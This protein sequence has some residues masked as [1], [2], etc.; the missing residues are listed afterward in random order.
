MIVSR[1]RRIIYSLLTLVLVAHFATTTTAQSSLIPNGVFE[2][3]TVSE[4]PYV[5]PIEW[6]SLNE[7]HFLLGYDQYTVQKTNDAYEGSFAL[8]IETQKLCTGVS[9]QEICL[10]VPGAAVLGELFIHPADLSIITFGVD[11]FERPE[12]MTGWYKYQPVSGDSCLIV[13]EL[14][15][16]NDGVGMREII[17]LG[18]FYQSSAIC[19]YSPLNIPI[20]YYS[21]STPEKLRIIAH[22]GVISTAYSGAYPV[23]STLLLDCITLGDE[24]VTTGIE[25]LYSDGDIQVYPSPAQ[26]SLDF[27]LDGLPADEYLIEVHSITGALLHT[28]QIQVQD[29]TNGSI[30]VS[31]WPSGTY[32][33]SVKSQSGYSIHNKKLFVSH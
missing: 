14:S 31:N 26:T 24:L 22:S 15:R 18:K 9:G 2:E 19:S 33:L 21:E 20:I 29:Q 10:L 3:W 4:I 16:F 13:V 1:Q 17:G 23:G 12:A 8:S 30:E 11:F 7:T 5:N 32:I 6:S 25:S 28:E 27:Q